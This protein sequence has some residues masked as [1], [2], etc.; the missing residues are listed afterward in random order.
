MDKN[1]YI[2]F[3]LIV[4]IMAGSYFFLKGPADQAR[5]EK[6]KQ[7]QQDSLRRVDSLAKVKAAAPSTPGVT[8]KAAGVDSSILKAPFG[9]ST[10]GTEKLITLESQDLLVKLSNRGGRI[11][12][13]E[14]KNYKTFD[15]KPL[16]LFKGDTN[17]FGLNLRAM[18]K[19]INTNDLYFTPSAQGLTVSGKDSSTISMRL[20]YSPTQ[21]IDYIYSL[22]GTGFKLGLTI[23]TT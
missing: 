5:K 6:A 23:K 1:S 7:E 17:T 13:V 19:P 2:G 11:Y 4:L 15:K 9:A 12:S 14:L 18:D 10:I 16:V 8:T 3:F 20:N 22:K 21:Y